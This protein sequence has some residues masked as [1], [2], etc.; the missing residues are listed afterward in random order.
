MI[1]QLNYNST[2]SNIVI[3]EKI[4]NFE[5][6]NSLVEMKR[7]IACKKRKFDFLSHK[8]YRK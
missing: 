4:T 1:N 5:L 3:Y 7:D 6:Y 8:I 2:T